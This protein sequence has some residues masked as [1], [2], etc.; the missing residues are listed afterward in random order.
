MSWMLRYTNW[1]QFVSCWWTI[2]LAVCGRVGEHQ[3]LWQPQM[4]PKSVSQNEQWQLSWRDGSF[5]GPF[6]SWVN[7]SFVYIHP[8]GRKSSG[9]W[10]KTSH[11]TIK[12]LFITHNISNH[13]FLKTLDFTAFCNFHTGRKKITNIELHV[14]LH[15][16]WCHCN[17]NEC[18]KLGT[19]AA[20]VTV[21][22]AV[23]S[24]AMQKYWSLRCFTNLVSKGVLPTFSQAA[25]SPRTTK[26]TEIKQ[27]FAHIHTISIRTIFLNVFGCNFPQFLSPGNWTQ[28]KQYNYIVFKLF[29]NFQPYR[30]AGAFPFHSR[31]RIKI[32]VRR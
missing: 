2:P 31:P 19:F 22:D 25:S 5:P 6:L 8:R 3:C 4:I 14:A 17:K 27:V 28:Q 30:H 20:R 15:G 23:V 7:E 26:V 29:V 24:L 18:E 1:P 12:L 16:F 21:F 9:N 13:Q 10:T 11:E 32:S